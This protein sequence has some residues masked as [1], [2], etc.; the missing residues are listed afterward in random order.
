MNTVE[1][2][3][4][5]T[6]FESFSSTFTFNTYNYGLDKRA[7][8]QGWQLTVIIYSG[9]HYNNC[10]YQFSNAVPFL[11]TYNTFQTMFG[12]ECIKIFRNIANKTNN[13][14]FINWLNESHIVLDII[15]EAL[16]SQYTKFMAIRRQFESRLNL[17]F[18]E[19]KSTDTYKKFVKEN[20]SE[21]VIR[22]FAEAIILL[23]DIFNNNEIR[24][25]LDL[26]ICR[27]IMGL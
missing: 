24:E 20:I 7:P 18:T 25:M 13:I 27:N 17:L 10:I 19:I 22:D 9:M 15:N 11:L 4:F 16:C 21:V 23:H 1:F 3:D 12:E 14:E 6:S 5:V 2:N 8:Q 26:A